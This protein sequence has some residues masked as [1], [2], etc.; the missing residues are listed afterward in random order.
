MRRRRRR[1]AMEP[2]KCR[3]KTFCTLIG[4]MRPLRTRST[5]SRRARDRLRGVK[6]AKKPH[7]MQ[8]SAKKTYP[9][10]VCFIW[11]GGCVLIR[12]KYQMMSRKNEAAML[13]FAR[14]TPKL[15]VVDART[16]DR[17]DQL[18]FA[19]PI[20]AKRCSQSKR[21]LNNHIFVYKAIA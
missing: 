1:F 20:S 3:P 19:P 5:L 21:T 12:R 8:Y 11:S 14:S 16:F 7:N 4:A 18:H 9:K 10:I 13:A 6:A 15:D 17:I 2:K